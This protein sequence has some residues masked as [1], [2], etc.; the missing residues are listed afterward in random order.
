MTLDMVNRNILTQQHLPEGEIV[1]YIVTSHLPKITSKATF[2]TKYTFVDTIPKG[3]TY[4]RDLSI[5][6]YD[7]EADAKANKTDAAVAHW[8]VNSKTS[9]AATM[10]HLRRLLSVQFR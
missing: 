10:Q 1:D 5:Y 9:E 8:D 4:N 7:N 2:L 3:L 6:F